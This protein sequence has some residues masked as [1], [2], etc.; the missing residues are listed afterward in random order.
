MGTRKKP[1]W[2]VDNGQPLP[3]I[4]LRVLAVVQKNSEGRK[5][6]PFLL[7]F[8]RGRAVKQD[9]QAAKGAAELGNQ[10]VQR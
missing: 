6:N 2:P 8:Q 9:N 10:D 4:W 3:N 1:K 5:A 7:W